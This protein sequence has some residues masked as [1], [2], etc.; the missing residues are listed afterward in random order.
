MNAA[1]IPELYKGHEVAVHSLTHPFLDNLPAEEI[2]HEIWED[3]KNIEKW[4]GYPVRGMAYPF[5]TYNQ[6]VLGVLET[7]GIEYS[8]TVKQH[9]NFSLPE[10][11][12]EWHPT[13]HHVNPK[14]FDLAKDFIQNK[15]GNLSLFYVWGHS[16]EFDVDEN[17]EL[18]EE[19]SKLIS[20]KEDIW[21]ATN[22]EIVD[23]LKALKNLKLSA[24][25]KLVY[26]PTA[27]SLWLEV[28]G[29]VVEVKSGELVKI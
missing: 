1:E 2:I 4:F 21:Y 10:N 28:D 29:K 6:T 8:R 5:G 3:R 22:I 13:C 7:L 26:N 20:N 9:E 23:Y 18:I 19:F 16:Y 15:P 14:L 27:I 25:K 11:F 12:L 24:D 17:W